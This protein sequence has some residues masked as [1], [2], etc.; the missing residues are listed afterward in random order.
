[1]NELEEC[2]EYGISVEEKKATVENCRLAMKE[3]STLF[4]YHHNAIKWLYLSETCIGEPTNNASRSRFGKLKIYTEV[5][6]S[7][8][9]DCCI[10][11]LR[12]DLYLMSLLDASVALVKERFRDI[13]QQLTH[14]KGLKSIEK[15]VREFIFLVGKN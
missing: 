14:L 12:D 15:Y 3:W 1:M 6:L 11:S 7:L 9:K 5:S 13:S 10:P 8:Y 2:D 4:T